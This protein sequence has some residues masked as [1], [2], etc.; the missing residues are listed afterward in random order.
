MHDKLQQRRRVDAIAARVDPHATAFVATEGPR[1]GRPHE[2]QLDAMW[3]SVEAGVPTVNGHS[4]NLPALW[5]RLQPAQAGVDPAERDRF[6]ARL[7]RWLAR[8][9]MAPDAVQWIEL[10]PDYRDARVS[11]RS[12]S[13]R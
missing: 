10:P 8:K 11:G 1:S 7:A 3:A 9:G 6:A 4:G 13:P 2:L 5:A 12:A